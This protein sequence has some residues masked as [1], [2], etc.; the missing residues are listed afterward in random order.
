MS[1]ARVNAILSGCFAGC[2]KQHCKPALYG[3]LV[4]PNI[5]VN[6]ITV[7]AAASKTGQHEPCKGECCLV[8]M[9]A[10]TDVPKQHCEPDLYGNLTHS[11]A[12]HTHELDST[13]SYKAQYVSLVHVC[14]RNIQQLIMLAVCLHAYSNTIQVPQIQ[15][16]HKQT[17][18][19][20]CSI[21]FLHAR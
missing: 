15:S 8:Y 7:V 13:G 4:I 10:A 12:Q 2:P 16:V 17:Y 18:T 3:N 21:L 5:V 11:D 6:W 19:Y 14:L 9:G 20:L 1:P